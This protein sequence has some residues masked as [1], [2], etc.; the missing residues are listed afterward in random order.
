MIYA[1]D[2]NIQMPT[3]DL[4]DTQIMAMAINAAKD[5]YDRGQKQ[6]DNFDKMYGDF[7]SPIKNDVQWYKENVTDRVAN[8]INKLYTMGIDPLRSAEGRNYVSQLIRSIDKTKINEMKANADLYSKRQDQIFKLGDLYNPEMDKFLNGD[9]DNFSTV[10]PDGTI[11]SFNYAAPTPYKDIDTLIEP[12]VKNIK[13][14]YDEKYTRYKN[15]GNDWY[16][17]TKDRLMQAVNDNMSDILT[18]PSGQFHYMQAKEEAKRLGDPTLADAIFRNKIQNRL[19]DH[20]DFK[21]VQ[22]PYKAADYKYKQAVSLENLRNKHL[23]QRQAAHDEAV[24]KMR[25]NIA[26]MKNKKSTS[27]NSSSDK[28]QYTDSEWQFKRLTTS[29][30]G[31]TSIGRDL[32]IGNASQFDYELMSGDTMKRAQQ[33]LIGKYYA[34]DTSKLPG[35]KPTSK[36]FSNVSLSNF[37]I[38]PVN[39]DQAIGTGNMTWDQVR[40][41]NSKLLEQMSLGLAPSKFTQGISREQVNITGGKLASVLL[42]EDVNR[43]YTGDYISLTTSGLSRPKD[44]LKAKQINESIRNKLSNI[45]NLIATGAG[46]I[47]GRVGLDGQ[48]RTFAKINLSQIDTIGSGSSEKLFIPNDIKALKDAIGD[49]TI[50]I[51]LGI[52]SY[53][54]PNYGINGNYD[55]NLTIDVNGQNEDT[56][57]IWDANVNKLLR[58]GAPKAESTI[59]LPQLFKDEN[60]DDYDEDDYFDLLDY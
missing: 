30:L 10:N 25:E 51:D 48:W 59:A 47:V 40:K 34:N 17:I 23:M 9:I 33:E 56:R 16:T 49:N 6:L 42:P 1:Y 21:P 43:I 12:I 28:E 53:S 26:P 11:N 44:V 31:K 27:G 18:T 45:Q 5:M 7:S 15:D 22:N 58:V 57:N 54:N 38:N 3:K 14:I 60:Q 29:I 2:Q 55:T 13:P 46:K 32:N 20:E 39:V 8:E 35:L 52:D 37:E 19:S 24:A 41:A 4:Y 36:P 50:Y